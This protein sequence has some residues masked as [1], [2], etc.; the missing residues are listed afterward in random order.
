MPL[1][2]GTC[3]DDHSWCGFL[4]LNINHPSFEGRQGVYII[5]QA[6][7]PII[8]VGQGIIRDRIQAH[9]SDPSITAY[10]NL[11]LTWAT[12]PSGQMDG[13]ER[14]LAERLH[15]AVGERFPAQA[16]AIPVNLPWPYP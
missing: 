10:P 5:W 2:W 15:P 16:A 11:Y 4:N 7:G 6:K 13:V 1:T 9:R 14:F 8:R 3:S 12:V